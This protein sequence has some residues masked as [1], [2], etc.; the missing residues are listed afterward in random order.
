[1]PDTIPNVMFKGNNTKEPMNQSN[2]INRIVEGTKITGDILAEN[3]VRIDGVLNGNI[4]I[5][6]KL[7]LGPTGKIEGEIN[8]LN[9]DIEGTIIGNIKVDGLLTLKETANIQGNVITNKI[10]VLEGANFTGNIQMNADTNQVYPKQISV[11]EE[12]NPE[13]VY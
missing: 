7:V 5:K 2:L 6:G 13:M 9:A 11:E 1:M 8:C 10:G 4:S 3:N 12:A